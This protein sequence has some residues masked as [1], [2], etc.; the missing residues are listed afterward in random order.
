MKRDSGKTIW[1]V[2]YYG[3]T[4]ETSM[5]GR[6]YY[7]ARELVASG[8]TVYLIAASYTHL[9]RKPPVVQHDIQLENV[10]GINVV[11][12][13]LGRY[14]HAHSR[15]RIINEFI[16]SWKFARL[17]RQLPDMPDVILCSSPSLVSF[18]AAEYVTRK[19]KTPLLCFEVRDIWP[20]T[21]TEIGGYSSRHPFV[22]LLQWI[23]NRAYR[24]ASRVISNLP[25]A[26]RHME[27]HGLKP[28]KFSWIPNGFSLEDFAEPEKLPEEFPAKL[29][30]DR[31][32][33]GYT[34]TLGKANALDILLDTAELLL[35]NTAVHFVIVGSGREA[36]A[37]QLEMKNRKLHNVTYMGAV[38]KKQ[39]P[40]VLACFDV[41]FAA[42]HKNRLYRYGTSLNKIPEYMISGKPIVYSVDSPYQPVAEAH[43]GITVP[44]EDSG[45]I[46][47]AVIQLQEMGKREREKLGKN[48]YEYAMKHHNYKILAQKLADIFFI[49]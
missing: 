39:I 27:Q 16:F 4:P 8:Y 5:G 40:A 43:A 34:G 6:H 45:A 23:E 19:L 7:L 11:Y 47:D 29:P 33:V 37:L 48:G 21:L 1:F 3:S 42:F 30:P 44:A 49:R 28:E 2:N 24:K 20:L 36:E 46:A 22:R 25:Y 31:M 12:V 10:E 9:L 32:I 26:V 14:R 35:N 13:K 18:L 41:C 17:F 38:A 15:K